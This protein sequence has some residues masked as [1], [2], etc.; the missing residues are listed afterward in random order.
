MVDV[1]DH[2]KNPKTKGQ[3]AHLSNSVVPSGLPLRYLALPGTTG[4][5]E[6]DV[7]TQARRVRGFLL[8]INRGDSENS[9]VGIAQT[10]GPGP[11][12]APAQP[13]PSGS[14]GPTRISEKG[15]HWVQEIFLNRPQPHWGQA[16]SLGCGLHP[17]RAPGVSFIFSASAFLFPP[18]PQEGMF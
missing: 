17:C 11:Q 2:K 12:P 1:S 10:P 4:K 15:T 3:L 9:S 16:A 5:G 14:K 7:P 6:R 18:C 8:P 13:V